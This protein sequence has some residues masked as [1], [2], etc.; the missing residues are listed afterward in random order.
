MNFQRDSSPAVVVTRFI[1]GEVAT[2]VALGLFMGMIG[3][4]VAILT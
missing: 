4:W 1:A 2:L 3:V